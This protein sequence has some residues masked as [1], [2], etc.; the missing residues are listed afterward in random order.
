[1]TD[2]Q[3]L[4]LAD[5]TGFFFDPDL[6]HAAACAR[7]LAFA[8]AILQAASAAPPIT[9][10][11]D[12][13]SVLARTV[14]TYGMSVLNTGTGEVFSPADIYKQPEA[15]RSSVAPVAPE[16]WKLV[17][18]EPTDDQ[19]QAMDGINND[20]PADE[21]RAIYRAMVEAAPHQLKD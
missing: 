12:L 18:V 1:M 8:R 21:V 16:G 15:N 14:L 10:A 4:Q 2:E 6:G 3:I 13:P 20:L 5:Q 17:P 11:L 7:T 19:L 9:D